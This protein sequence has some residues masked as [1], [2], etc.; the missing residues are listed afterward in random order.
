MGD[1]LPGEAI[2]Q[3]SQ[4][5]TGRCSS[6]TVTTT[7]QCQILYFLV[8]LLWDPPFTADGNKA[9][10]EIYSI[11]QNIFS[12]VKFSSPARKDNILGCVPTPWEKWFNSLYFHANRLLSFFFFASK[13]LIYLKGHFYLKKNS[14]W[15]VSECLWHWI[16]SCFLQ[17]LSHKMLRA[18]F[19]RL[20]F[21]FCS[22]ELHSHCDQ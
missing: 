5:C 6:I 10:K 12:S 2:T 8:R 9:N 1:S 19:P 21:I 20:P 11:F 7:P 16:T 13:M 3:D 14:S 22:H 4:H 18:G 15:R 17:H